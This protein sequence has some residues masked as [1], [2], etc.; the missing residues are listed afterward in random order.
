MT[1]LVDGGARRGS[2]SRPAR[3]APAGCSVARRARTDTW[4]QVAWARIL[5]VATAA[6]CC[7]FLHGTAR[8]QVGDRGVELKT[9]RAFLQKK[10]PCAFWYGD[11]H[12]YFGPERTLNIHVT[13]IFD[14]VVAA[15]T[16]HEARGCM[17]GSYDLGEDEYGSVGI[18]DAPPPAEVGKRC[19]KAVMLR[20]LNA[21]RLSHIESTSL[22]ARFL[23]DFNLPPKNWVETKANLEFG[24]SSAD[25]RAV[26]SEFRR[27]ACEKGGAAFYGESLGCKTR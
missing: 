21:P 7:L 14:G 18:G 8:A 27:L 25:W 10:K 15:G 1:L 5:V 16:V 26:A 3:L 4:H 13:C 11:S 20:L 17:I 12:Q 6:S 9:A 19:T 22:L 24:G 2:K 23:N